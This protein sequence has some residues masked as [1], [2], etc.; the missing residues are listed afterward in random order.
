MK[1]V[2]ILIVTYNRLNL[3]KAEIESLKKQTY[4][5]YDIIVV[6]N[7]SNDGTKE[8]LHTQK[9]IIT[10]N[11]ENTG[12]AGGFYT[13]LKYI[14]EHH[15]DYC[16]LMDDDV[17]CMPNSL[18]ILVNAAKENNISGF[19]CSRVKS[20]DGLP[21][22]VP[23]IDDRKMNGNYPTWLEK[24]DKNLIK[25]KSCTFVSVLIPT[26]ICNKLGLPLKEYFIWGDDTEYTLRISKHY[27]CYL[28]YESV[29]IHKREIQ[30]SL[31]I[32]TETNPRRIKMYYFALRNS[33]YNT[34]KYG[35]SKDIFINFCYL[36]SLL[37]RSLIKFKFGIFFTVCK[38]FKSIYIFK[39][40]IEYPNSK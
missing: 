34:R 14:T 29:V 19:T 5:D 3:L 1:T 39:P 31:D 25:V 10:I 15:Y 23:Q 21:M 36:S 24:I 30:K 2:G 9:D 33:F 32:L 17:E 35:K 27:D 6:N 16:W 8:W 22:N 12:G 11:Q 28:A 20:M 38:V 7:G 40:K 4:K 13:G 26:Y 37:F 18:D